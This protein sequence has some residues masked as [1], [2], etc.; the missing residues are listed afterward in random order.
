MFMPMRQQSVET[1]VL[2]HSTSGV[3]FA[4]S[5]RWS[6]STEKEGPLGYECE[7][8]GQDVSLPSNSK[9]GTPVSYSSQP[10]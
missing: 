5:D 4:L 9:L 3:F 7:D 2:H 8:I 1:L 6:V 10:G